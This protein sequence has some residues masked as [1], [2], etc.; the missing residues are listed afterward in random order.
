MDLP[1]RL[2][3]QRGFNLIE[4]M[5]SGAIFLIGML[6]I[7]PLFSFTVQQTSRARSVTNAQLVAFDV[8]ERLRAEVQWDGNDQAP[9]V[10]DADQFWNA[11]YL[12][13]G[14]NYDSPEFRV[15]R[16][17]EVYTVSYSLRPAPAATDCSGNA[18]DPSRAPLPLNARCATVRVRWPRPD[19]RTGTFELRTVLLGVR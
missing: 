5:V 13:H 14:A 2:R 1:M 3:D 6:A 19:G 10:L 11:P 8:I 18:I 15:S 16:E 7:A 9:V 17:E 4:V 12:P